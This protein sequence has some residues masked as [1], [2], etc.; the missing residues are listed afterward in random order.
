ME[1]T[2]GGILAIGFIE[3]RFVDFFFVYFR[4]DSGHGEKNGKDNWNENQRM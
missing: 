3:I 2:P 4:F 1:I